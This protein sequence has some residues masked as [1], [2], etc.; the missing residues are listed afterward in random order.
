MRGALVMLGV[1]VVLGMPPAQAARRKGKPTSGAARPGSHEI[2]PGTFC[3][4][5]PP[6]PK[7]SA[8]YLPVVVP[9]IRST[10][11]N[12]LGATPPAP[13]L[14]LGRWDAATAA[15]LGPAVAAIE[16]GLRKPG[17]H[18]MDSTAAEER[19]WVSLQLW[20]ET[21][22]LDSE[23]FEIRALS[24]P[25][26]E[27]MWHAVVENYGIFGTAGCFPPDDAVGAQAISFRVDFQGH[28]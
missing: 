11:C 15:A 4:V 24:A 9:K 28:L 3:S 5:F 20:L 21:I 16:A 1:V 12:Y 17:V 10:V 26:L 23:A 14:S 22:A 13:R 2:I 8:E 18:V 19:P 25:I 27:A 7:V 6:I